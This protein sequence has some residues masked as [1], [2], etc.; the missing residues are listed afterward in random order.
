MGYSM[1]YACG[2]FLLFVYDL[3]CNFRNNRSVS[4]NQKYNRINF[5]GVFFE[6]FVTVDH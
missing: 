3:K 2:G 6:P 5:I 4:A 1:H